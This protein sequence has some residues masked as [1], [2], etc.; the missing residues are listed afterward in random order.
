MACRWRA[1]RRSRVR[2]RRRGA[3]RLIVVSLCSVGVGLL[4]GVV[5]AA[6]HLSAARAALARMHPAAL[7]G[8]LHS[9]Y[10]VIRRFTA[11]SGLTGW[12]MSSPQGRYVVVY[13]TSDGRALISGRVLTSSGE[14]LTS[15]YAALYIPKLDLGT[16]WKRFATKASY[17]ASGASHPKSVIY[18]IVD[19][20]CIYCHM[21]WIALRGYE[22]AGLQVRWIPVGFLHAD[23]AAKAAAILQGGDPVLERMEEKFD[24]HRESGGVPGIAI[25]PKLAQELKANTALMHAAKIMGTP[26]ILYRDQAGH[27]HAR[28]G[29]PMMTQLPAITGLPAQKETAAILARFSR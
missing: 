28:Y 25:T 3:A 11:V 2:S 12:I 27:V 16:L 23:S 18:V 26:G 6:L 7:E 29:M 22:A 1:R 24:V 17:I 5:F 4:V 15:R 10:Q 9:G 13:T 14:N 8:P 19:P 21:L 20:N